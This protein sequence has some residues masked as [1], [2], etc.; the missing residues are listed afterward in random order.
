[1]E[2]L[3]L[4][5]FELLLERFHAAWC[6]PASFLSMIETRLSAARAR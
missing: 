4:D 2:E 5:P 1:L 3:A 6:L